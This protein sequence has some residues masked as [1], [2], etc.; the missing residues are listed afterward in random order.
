MYFTYLLFRNA[1]IPEIGESF[2]LWSGGEGG[3]RAA[4]N[5][6]GQGILGFGNN[7]PLFEN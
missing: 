7:G 5:W 1:K 3:G 6:P 2:P 4:G